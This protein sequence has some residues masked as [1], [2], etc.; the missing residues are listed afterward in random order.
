[1]RFPL[2]DKYTYLNTAHSGLLSQE[3]VDQRRAW[4]RAW[5]HEGSIRVN[6]IYDEMDSVRDTVRP[7]LGA[8]H[9]QLAL[10]P[11]LSYGL[12]ALLENASFDHDVFIIK[13]DYPSFTWPFIT[14]G[15][16]HET[17]IDMSAWDLDQLVDYIKRKSPRAFAFSAVQYLT[18]RE[19]H[20]HWL[21]AI[22]KEFPELLIIMDGTQFIGT[23]PFS[24]ESAGVDLLIGSGYKWIGAGFHNAYVAISPRMAERLH[25]PTRGYNSVKQHDWVD[26]VTVQQ[27]LEPGHQSA[28]AFKSL[29]YGIQQLEEIGLDKIENH[30]DS[31]RSVISGRIQA[32][33]GFMDPETFAT[34]TLTGIES[35]VNACIA[36]GILC[37]YRQGIRISYHHYNTEEHI[38]RFFDVLTDLRNS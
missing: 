3:L 5:M 24:M 15:F 10:V 4:D 18:G 22:K 19:V 25:P 36:E 38:H 1:M 21:E 8:E 27:A 7:F 31:L 6:A 12:N 26:E 30:I 9:A 2:L 32:M 17:Q 11:S 28:L 34:Q 35:E 33:G 23:G 29:Q 20:R 13:D 37:S 14:R 16:A